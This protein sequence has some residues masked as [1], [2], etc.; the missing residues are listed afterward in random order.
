MQ[1]EGKFLKSLI[2]VSHIEFQSYDFYHHE[3]IFSSGFAQQILGYSKDEYSK[4]SRKFYEDLIYPDDIPMMHEA[5]NKIIHSSPGEIIEMTARYKR[6]NGNYIWMYTR[7]VVSERDK[8]GYP[9][10][11]T[12]I[13]EDITK[14]IE[15]QDQLKEKV[16]L[17]Q[18]ISYKNS[19]MLRSP[20]ASIIGLINIIEEKD[21]M[22]PHNLKIFNFLKQAIEKLDSVVH[23]INEISQM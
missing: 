3:L 16:K 7:K 8:Q 12:T 9:C 17:L 23:E 5:I 18:A 20:V 19:H 13:A 2:E 10:T 21:T 6:S 22:S 14:L 11:I 4:F 1:P 15:L